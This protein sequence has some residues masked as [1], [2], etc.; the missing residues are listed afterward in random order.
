MEDDAT[1][2]EDIKLS[3]ETTDEEIE[4][5][6]GTIPLSVARKL[7]LCVAYEQGGYRRWKALSEELKTVYADRKAMND[8]EHTIKSL[9][10]C[11]L[12][13]AEQLAYDDNKLDRK[14]KHDSAEVISRRH[15][16]Q[17]ALLRMRSLFGKVV[18]YCHPIPKA[19]LS[20]AAQEEKDAKEAAQQVDAA[21]GGASSSSSSSSAGKF[22]FHLTPTL[23]PLACSHP[24]PRA[25]S[26]AMKAI[27]LLSLISG[28]VTDVRCGNGKY[29][30]SGTGSCVD[31]PAGSFCTNSDPYT[32][33]NLCLAVRLSHPFVFALSVSTPQAHTFFPHCAGHVQ[34]VHGP[35]LL[36]VLRCGQVQSVHWELLYQRVLVLR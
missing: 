5:R 28:A 36:L 7:I 20:K 9:I 6:R 21:G 19:K 11:G 13:T 14:S 15:A 26:T 2:S 29:Y 27:L 18:D 4:E 24:L 34:S 10:I 23:V 3:V 12:S 25:H 33:K 30:F 32:F 16:H 8:D 22:T 31:C 17:R 35:V 1:L